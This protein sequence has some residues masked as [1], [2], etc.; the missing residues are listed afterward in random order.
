[1]HRDARSGWHA[2][3][4]RARDRPHVAARLGFFHNVN[5]R[6]ATRDARVTDDD[7]G[8]TRGDAECYAR[9]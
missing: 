6:R 2:L 5:A 4:L 7:A 9:R 8:V 1:M 3:S